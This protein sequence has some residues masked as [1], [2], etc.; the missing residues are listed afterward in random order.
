M[1][2][3]RCPEQWKLDVNDRYQNA[4]G[5]VMSLASAALMIPVFFLKDIVALKSDEAIISVLD[6]FV[7]VGWALLGSSIL[8]GI[9]YCFFSA[10]WV[11]LAW[12]KNA[13]ICGFPISHAR[14]EK[15]LD[16]SYFIMMIGFL[17]GTICMIK[18]I[19]TYVIVAH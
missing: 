6:G 5:L 3:K 17:I 14:V 15:L 12:K 7:F 4:V 18:F 13:D 2:D 9:L 8:S 10:K 19:A 16:Y 1:R 11:K